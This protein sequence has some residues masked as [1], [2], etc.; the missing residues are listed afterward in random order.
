M[1]RPS[2]SGLPYL[3]VRPDSGK[4]AY[5]RILPKNVAPFL[6]GKLTLPWTPIPTILNAPKIIKLSLKTG[7]KPT[8]QLRWAQV[9]AQVDSLIAAAL[10]KINQTK[11]TEDARKHLKKVDTLTQAQIDV[12]AG[13]ARHDVLA[14]DDATWT[15]ADK[16]KPLTNLVG[17]ILSDQ[18]GVNKL[19][20]L[21][22]SRAISGRLERRVVSAALKSR[23]LGY[24]DQ[25]LILSKLNSVSNSETARDEIKTQS[26]LSDRL[27]ENGFELAK[28]DGSRLKLG[29]AILR[30]KRQGYAEVDS[31]ENGSPMET[32]PR[33]ELVY[34]AEAETA[35]LQTPSTRFTLMDAHNAWVAKIEPVQKSIDDNKLYIDRFV[36]MHGDLAIR[37]ITGS[38]VKTYR[39]KLS[40]FPRNQPKHLVNASPDEIIAWAK[41]HPDVEKLSKR[42]VNAKGISSI[43][44]LFAIPISDNLVAANP[45]L[46]KAFKIKKGGKKARKPLSMGDLN[47]LLCSIIYSDP[48]YRPTAGCGEAAFWLPLLGLFAG[49]RLEELGQLRVADIMTTSGICYISIAFDESDEDE[50]FDDDVA[51][52]AAKQLKNAWSVRKIPVHKVLIDLGFLEY[53][54]ERK[55]SNKP[56]LFPHLTEYRGRLTKNWSRWFGRYLDKHVT[57]SDQKVFHSFRHTF[58]DGLTSAKITKDYIRAALGHGDSDVTD[59]YGDGPSLQELNTEIQKLDFASLGLDLSKIVRKKGK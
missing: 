39:D 32:P 28:H 21:E 40:E 3:V 19:G 33:P 2:L 44:K 13:Q 58:K 15:N 1:A 46:G 5:W 25:D 36:A 37:D 55:L 14:D 54:N 35:L 8:A 53:V 31:R 59:G 20:I 48:S 9:H 45:C 41:E 11:K 6:E 4:Y 7:D 34:K 23:K 56:L 22:R 52:M 50:D 42:T 57:K 49:G 47:K 43:S 29:V 18:A 27:A 38:H 10:E 51:P 17:Q 26:E 12:I 16:T 24:L 30:A